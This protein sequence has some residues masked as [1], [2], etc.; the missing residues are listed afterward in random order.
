M[1]NFSTSLSPE[2]E[3]LSQIA[4]LIREVEA[5]HKQNLQTIK[6]KMVQQQAVNAANRRIVPGGK[7][8]LSSLGDTTMRIEIK[9]SLANKIFNRINPQPQRDRD[10]NLGLYV[11][12]RVTFEDLC[13]IIDIDVDPDCEG[14][15]WVSD[16]QQ[17]Y[18]DMVS[19]IAGSK[20]PNSYFDAPETFPQIETYEATLKYMTTAQREEITFDLTGNDD[21]QALSD[22]SDKVFSS[23]NSIFKQ[24]SGWGDPPF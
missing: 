6:E 12:D 17:G 11:L 16:L 21:V 10:V 8:I 3:K 18:I 22:I 24:A 4:D 23:L 15:I 19:E 13:E 5:E 1:G 7:S 9:R 20:S 2:M 14:G